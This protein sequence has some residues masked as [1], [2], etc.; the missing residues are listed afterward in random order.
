V[1]LLDELIPMTITENVPEAS[2]GLSDMDNDVSLNT[3][4]LNNETREELTG[5]EP[6]IGNPL[7]QVTRRF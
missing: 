1:Y 2:L 4:G 7:K 5:N 3:K 6:A